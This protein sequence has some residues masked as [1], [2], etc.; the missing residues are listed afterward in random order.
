MFVTN[1]EQ[2]LFDQRLARNLFGSV[3]TRRPA[4]ESLSVLGCLP[5]DVLDESED[6]EDMCEDSQN[7]DADGDVIDMRAA[8]N[9]ADFHDFSDV[10]Y[11]SDLHLTRYTRIFCNDG[12]RAVKK[13]LNC[14]V[15]RKCRYPTK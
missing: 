1:S 15:L 5:S 7:C 10:A 8:V 11:N 4:A 14:V 2:F 9:Q 3:S 12:Q 6:C 13:K